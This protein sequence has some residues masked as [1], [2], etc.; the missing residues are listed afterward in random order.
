MVGSSCFVEFQ[1]TDNIKTDLKD[2]NILNFTTMLGNLVLAVYALSS[3]LFW[4]FCQVMGCKLN[5]SRTMVE[6]RVIKILSERMS[7]AET[8]LEAPTSSPE[9]LCAWALYHTLTHSPTPIRS[10]PSGVKSKSK[11]SGEK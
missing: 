11:F 10:L 4:M 3:L 2:G 9:C 1:L 5:S 7:N 8:N 6:K